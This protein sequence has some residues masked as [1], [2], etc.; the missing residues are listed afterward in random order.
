[1]NRDQHPAAPGFLSCAALGALVLALYG[2]HLDTGYLADDFLFLEWAGQGP[3]ELLRRV[4]GAVEPR[5][6]RPLPAFLWY[7]GPSA[8]GAAVHHAVSL[9]V[10]TLCGV[11]VARIAT[12][13]CH[14]REAGLIAGA[15]FLAFPLFTEPVIWLAAGPDLWACCFALAALD[16]SLH[17]VASARLR[18]NVASA[19]RRRDVASARH[20]ATA[21][22]TAG[23]AALFAAGLLSKESVFM[24]PLV[25]LF[26][27]PWREGRRLF[28]SLSLVAGAYLGARLALIGGPGGYLD[29]EGRSLNL[30]FDPVFFLRNVCLQLPYR[31][32]VP[33]KRAGELLLPLAVLST[34]LALALAATARIWRRPRELTTAGAAA[35]VALLPAAPLFSI[36]VDHESSRMLYFPVAI[37]A[38]AGASCLADRGPRPSLRLAAVLVLAYWGTVTI[39]N[40]RAWSEASREIERT[41]TLMHQVE[42]RYHPGS[43]VLIAGHDTW[44]GAYVWRNGLAFAGRLHGLRRDL[45]WTLG[46]AAV[47][48]DAGRLGQD[49]FEIGLDADGQ[50]VDWTTCER[51]LR[52]PDVPIL[53]S[54]KWPP[55]GT[56]AQV[57]PPRYTLTPSLS[58]AHET[59]TPAVRLRF[60]GCPGER[61]GPRGHAS[62]LYWRENGRLGARFNVTDARIFRLPDTAP[63]EVVVRLATTRQ[64]LGNL[65]LRIETSRP[66]WLACLREAEVLDGPPTCGGGADDP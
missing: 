22:A 65:E 51:M 12:R 2:R 58:L 16:L 3:A 39:A 6:L 64:A 5:F 10:H 25:T 27:V 32:L 35:V 31:L 26:L 23:A 24:L 45:N 50:A 15:L 7:L 63:G 42:D 55:T 47:L 61:Q 43:T 48:P 9:A 18:R 62:R 11:L 21:L 13:R 29:A 56:K 54:Y 44:K 49:A 53:A 46:T 20:G 59:R 14:S 19:R 28:L 30:G 33:L 66:G 57:K 4:T 1:M 52:A 38:L 17:P 36:D 37:L 8:A 34:V 40:G 41:L 60:A